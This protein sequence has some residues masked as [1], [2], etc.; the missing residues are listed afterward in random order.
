MGAK[1]D[2]KERGLNWEHGFSRV[3]GF[4][5]RSDIKEIDITEFRVFYYLMYNNYLVRSGWIL[6]DERSWQRMKKRCRGLGDWSISSRRLHFGRKFFFSETQL[7]LAP[8]LPHKSQRFQKTSFESEISCGFWGIAYEH[9]QNHHHRGAMRVSAS[10]FLLLQLRNVNASFWVKFWEFLH[11]CSCLLRCRLLWRDVHM[12][13]WTTFMPLCN[14]WRWW[15]MLKLICSS[16]VAT[17]RWL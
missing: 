15:R 2:S 3:W 1:H 12:A 8:G 16:A 5:R 9:A 17:S 7:D 10:L 4:K 6:N 13:T 14:T 11:L